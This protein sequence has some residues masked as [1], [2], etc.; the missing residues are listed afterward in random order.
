MAVQWVRTAVLASALAF[1]TSPAAAKD[2]VVFGLD[3]RA[4]SEYGGFYQAAVTGIYDSYGLDVTLKSGGPQINTAQLLLAGALDIAV[5]GDSFIPINAVKEGA[6]YTTVAAF[7]QKDPICI[8]VHRAAGYT[9]LEQLKGKPILVSTDAWDSWWKW[10]K[11]KYGYADSQGRPYPYSMV[12]WLNDK[13]L[14]QQSYITNEPYQLMKA[15]GDP[16]TFLLADYG[17]SAYAN[18][19]MT[20]RKLIAERPELVRRFI[21]A[22][23]KGWYSFMHDDHTKALAAIEKD[24][25][26]YTAGN[27]E[28]SI[29]AMKEHG[30][31]ESGDAKTLG[32][33]A[34]TDARWREFFDSMVTAG[35]YPAGFDYK[36]A[37]TLQFV[38][39]GLGK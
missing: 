11:A 38:D 28:F 36:K 16:Q 8:I 34:M 23:I 27:A 17:F 32:I 6:N 24:N 19:A 31:V 7:F 12:P 26:D 18:L 35:L 30:L 29:A 20:S 25:P 2:K 33:G 4:Q 22:S 15:G 21:D 14:S 13:T 3:W 10:A 5:V 9:S 39:K 1:A 37:Y